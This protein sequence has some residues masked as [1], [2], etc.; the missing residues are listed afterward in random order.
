MRSRLADKL[1]EGVIAIAPL[2]PLSLLADR[3]LIVAMVLTALVLCTL[4]RT[5]ASLRLLLTA[6]SLWKA[7]DSSESAEGTV[8]DSLNNPTDED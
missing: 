2:A 3:P 8:H 5:P 4:I 1:R 6:R 7:A